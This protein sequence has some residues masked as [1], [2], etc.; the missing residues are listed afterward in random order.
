MFFIP[1]WIPNVLL[2]FTCVLSCFQ[3]VKL[4]RPN[5][6][7]TLQFVMTLFCMLMVLVIIFYDTDNPWVSLLF[8]LIAAGSTALMIRQQRM[9]PPSKPFE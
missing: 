9:L 4:A 8:F 2:L 5:P 6:V 3:L 7:T 1:I